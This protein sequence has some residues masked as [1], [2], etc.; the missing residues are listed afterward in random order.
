MADKT[1]P[2]TD[3]ERRFV[4]EY[5][6]DRNGVRSWRAVHGA[7]QTY[8]AAAVS[9]SQLLKKPKIKAEIAAAE[10]AISRRC[11]VSAERVVREL[12]AVAFSDIGDHVDYTNEGLPR[13][14]PGKSVT[15]TARKSLKKIKIKTRR[16]KSHGND[17]SVVEE[18][19]EAEVELYDKLSAL[20]KLS[21]QLGLFKDEAPIEAL[22]RQLPAELRA[23][24]AAELSKAK[25]PTAES[26]PPLYLP[27]LKPVDTGEGT[28]EPTS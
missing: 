10:C 18:V 2:L 23:Q 3:E 11:R 8:A 22:L 17:D 4:E 9:A 14:K 7:E 26:I 1:Q 16:L 28:G 21:K 15:A 20:D 25:S 19:E 27:P 13:L 5:L 24:V 6:I 12:A